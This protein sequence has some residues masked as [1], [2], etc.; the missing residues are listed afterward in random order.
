MAFGRVL[1]NDGEGNYK[2]PL[3]LSLKKGSLLVM[4]GNSS[5][6]ARHVMCSSL[7]RRVSISFF[8]VRTT[9]LISLDEKPLSN[10]SKM[11]LWQP[12]VQNRNDPIIMI[13]RWG[14][15]MPV[16]PLPMLVPVVHHHQ[17]VMTPPKRVIQ[18]GDSGGGTG[19]FLP[20]KVGTRKPA[21][22][23]PPRARRSGKS[24]SLTSPVV[25]TC[26]NNTESA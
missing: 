22:Q 11:S 3:V 23:V 2:A 1:T 6:T 12:I 14:G 13:P 10:T 8:R 24:P 21:R 19:F 18:N 5:S 15:L 25:E 26:S 17:M 20:W 4:R 16:P 7:N 9:D